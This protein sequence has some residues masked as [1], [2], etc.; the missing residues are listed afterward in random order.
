MAPEMTLGDERYGIG[1]FPIDKVDIYA[2]GMT[3]VALIIEQ[4]P[5]SKEK[6]S[7]NI[8]ARVGQKK[9]EQKLPENGPFLFF[10]LT[11]RCRDLKL[12]KRPP[13]EDITE[14]LKGMK[15]HVISDI[16]K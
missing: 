6:N 8:P 13:A 3:Y 15:T 5:Y 4:E 9:L 11:N 14:E 2:L 1:K 16:I 7:M 12:E 10:T